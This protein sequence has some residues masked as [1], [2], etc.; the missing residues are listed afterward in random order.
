VKGR[1]IDLMKK[2]KIRLYFDQTGVLVKK[3]SIKAVPAS[4]EQEGKMLRVKE[5]A[6]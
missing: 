5:V 3:F 2:K 1:V 6:I 4:V